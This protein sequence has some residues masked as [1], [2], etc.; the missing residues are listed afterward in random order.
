MIINILHTIVGY[1]PT[2]KEVLNDYK[3]NT[4]VF[5]KGEGMICLLFSY[6]RYYNY[7]SVKTN[8]KFA[9][10]RSYYINGWQGEWLVPRNYYLD[11]IHSY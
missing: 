5:D 7:R 1:I 2:N 6:G 4:Q 3:S 10:L 11:N 9:D 8:Y